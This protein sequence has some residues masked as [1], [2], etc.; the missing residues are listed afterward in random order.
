MG[1]PP[2]KNNMSSSNVLSYLILT[3]RRFY[4][5]KN[6]F[7]RVM[8]SDGQEKW[9]GGGGGKKKNRDQIK[10][11][12]NTGLFRHKAM[13]LWSRQREMLSV[14]HSVHLGL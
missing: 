10:L 8:Q 4:P 11:L 13:I 3:T 2:P 1:F 7:K 6:K 9:P 14:I 12:D 5:W